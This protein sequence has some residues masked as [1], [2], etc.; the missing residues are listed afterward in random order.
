MEFVLKWQHSK[1]IKF[2]LYYLKLIGIPLYNRYKYKL[3]NIMENNLQIDNQGNSLEVLDSK[4]TNLEIIANQKED[5]YC[6]C[7]GECTCGKPK[8]RCQCT[9]K[10][11]CDNLD[12]Q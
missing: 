4:N 3:N 6:Q 8:K 7:I 11:E 1:E 5:Q 9:G 2:K 12:R 10:C